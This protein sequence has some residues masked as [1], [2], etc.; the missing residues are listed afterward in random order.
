MSSRHGEIKQLPVIFPPVPDELLSSWIARHGAFYNVSPRAMLRHAVPEAHS[1]RSADDHLADKQVQLL[2]HIFRQ[3]PSDIRRMTFLNIETTARRLISAEVIQSCQTCAID[4]ADVGATPILRSWR[5]A[6][7]ITCP[8]CH[9]QLGGAGQG[10][11]ANSGDSTHSLATWEDALKGER[12]LDDYAERGT[13]TWASPIDVL[14]LLLMRRDPKPI[15]PENWIETPKILDLLVPGFDR[16]AAAAAI[17]IPPVARPILPLLLRPALLAGIAI[18]ERSGPKI[19]TELHA[20]TM[21]AYHT[22][23]GTIA[24][25]IL[26]PRQPDS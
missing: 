1:L 24:T 23:F 6:W 15:D 3:E 10:S 21:G 14:K 16:L 2:A 8:I 11:E 17:A 13:Q 22:H 5:Q 20:R 9:S 19:V 12:L 4:K 26:A 7:R 18:V 25:K